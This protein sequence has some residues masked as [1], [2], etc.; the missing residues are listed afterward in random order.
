MVASAERSGHFH[1]Q[2]HAQFAVAAGAVVVASTIPLS[3]EPAGAVVVASTIPLS[4][5]VYSVSVS[6][7]TVK[8]F[9]L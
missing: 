4:M 8:K 9:F 1:L 7:A 2:S 6:P 3:G 5:V